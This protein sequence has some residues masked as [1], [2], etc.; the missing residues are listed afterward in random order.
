VVLLL[1]GRRVTAAGFPAVAGYSLP[2]SRSHADSRVMPGATPT[3]AQ[4][5]PRLRVRLTHPAK[6]SSSWVATEATWGSNGR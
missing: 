2:E 5:M 3:L 6:L 1:T 4:L